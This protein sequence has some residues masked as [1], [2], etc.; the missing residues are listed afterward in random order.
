MTISLE[1]AGAPGAAEVAAS[2]WTTPPWVRVAVHSV[3]TATTVAA[4]TTLVGF[5]ALS[6][7]SEPRPEAPSA[8]TGAEVPGPLDALMTQNRCSFTGFDKDVIPS[9]ALVRTPAGETEVVS[10]D[11]GW[12]VFLGKSAGELVAVCLGPAPLT[13]AAHAD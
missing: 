9:T 6:A 12:A 7:F 13:P 5:G 4:L 3:R 8:S 11:A 10:F 1:R 2:R